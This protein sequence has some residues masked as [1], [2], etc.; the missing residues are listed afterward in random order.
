MVA[1]KNIKNFIKF[2]F[3]FYCL[4]LNAALVIDFNDNN[5]TS[6]DFEIA[7]FDHNNDEFSEYSAWIEE[8]DALLAV[9]KNKNGIIDNGAELLGNNTLNNSVYNRLNENAIDA[10]AALKEFDS[11]KNNII[12]SNDI[13]SSDLLLWFDKNT[14]AKTDDG[15]LVKLLQKVKSIDLNFKDANRLENENEIKKSFVATLSDGNNVGIND[16]YFLVDLQKTEI[17]DLI[18]LKEQI[19]KRKSTLDDNKEADRKL[20]M[21]F[22]G[23]IIGINN[24]LKLPEVEAKGSL[25]SLRYAMYKND[26]LAILM[27]S[28][29]KLSPQKRKDKIRDII[30][31]WAG[32]TDIDP[33]AM[34]G[35]VLARDMVVYEKSYGCKFLQRGVNPNPTPR[36]SKIIKDELRKLTNFI[37]SAIELQTT[38]K[39]LKINYKEMK[40]NGK[41]YA[42]DFNDA[43][44]FARGLK[45]ANET[46]KL[47]EF[48]NIMNSALKYRPSAR[49][50]FIKAKNEAFAKIPKLYTAQNGSD[51][52]LKDIKEKLEIQKNKEKSNNSKIFIYLAIFNLILASLTFSINGSIFSDKMKYYLE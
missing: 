4:N 18:K 47:N 49:K 2:S 26:N 19:Y 29:L 17:I 50:E 34:R 31:E 41:E 1:G 30:Y 52:F 12:D 5:V 37:Y 38:Y 27:E 45:I 9:D 20:R 46:S 42:Y 22:T 32:A 43:V 10:F 44:K 51:E 28:Y 39:F 24:A 48:L 13:N 33:N 15:E 23:D 6:T 40:F 14:D 16:I 25:N 8:G 21:K 11:D 3:L 7:H 35:G 36:A